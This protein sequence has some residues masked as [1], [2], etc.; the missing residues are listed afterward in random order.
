MDNCRHYGITINYAYFV[1]SQVAMTRVLY[2]R[3]LRGEIGDEEWEYRKRQ[4]MHIFGPLNLR[5]YMD[6]RWF[7][8]GGLGEVG[9]NVGYLH[10]ILPFMP[11]GS[12]GGIRQFDWAD[13]AP[14]F[15]SLLSFKRFLHRTKLLKIQTERFTKH[16]NFVDIILGSHSHSANRSRDV[17]MEWINKDKTQS[18]HSPPMKWMGNG[19]SVSTQ[20]GTSVGNVR[21]R[22]LPLNKLN[23]S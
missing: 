6:Q 10:C 9:L 5:P 17:A 13:G 23:S 14:P 3:Y 11:L 20:I 1:L 21:L 18:A 8:N 22:N 15:S 16:P 19:C 2:R 12:S 7:Q 4:P